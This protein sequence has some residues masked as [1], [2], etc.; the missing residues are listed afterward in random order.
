MLSFLARHTQKQTKHSSHSPERLWSV[1]WVKS[2]PGVCMSSSHSHYGLQAHYGP[3]PDFVSVVSSVAAPRPPVI[4]TPKLCATAILSHCS[5][6]CVSTLTFTSGTIRTNKTWFR[7]SW[8]NYFLIKSPFF[9]S[10]ARIFNIRLDC[11]S[12]ILTQSSLI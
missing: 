4:A 10:R 8:I 11:N 5:Y 2:L 12:V 1:W 3:T 7:H 9:G 6:L